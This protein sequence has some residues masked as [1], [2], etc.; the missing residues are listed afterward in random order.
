MQ[1]SHNDR[2]HIIGCLEM[3]GGMGQGG[4]RILET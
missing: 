4:E 1:S 2:M 3:G